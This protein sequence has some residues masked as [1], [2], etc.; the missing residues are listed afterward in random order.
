MSTFT[1]KLFYCYFILKIRVALSM[2]YVRLIILLICCATFSCTYAQQRLDYFFKQ[3]NQTD[4]LLHNEVRSITQDKKGYIWIAS[5]NGLQR[6]DGASFVNYPQMQSNPA[7]G[8]YADKVNNVLW[9]TDNANIE[10]MDL[11]KNVFQLYSK[12]TLLNNPLFTFDTYLDKNN[13]KWLLGDNAVY[14]YNSVTNKNELFQL[15][16]IP[17]NSH[18]ASFIVTDS[19]EMYS[20]V[21]TGST[22]F[23]FDK[24]NKRVYADSF[25]IA[26]IPLV[27]LSL[28]KQKSVLRY[29]MLDSK[30]NIWITTWG[31]V[32]IKINDETKKINTYSLSAIK[33]IQEGKKVSAAGLLINCMMEDN[34]HTIW[35]GTENAGLLKYNNEKDNFAYCIAQEKNSKGLQYTYKI[36]NLFQDKEQNIW[37]ATD[38]GISIFNPY[39]QYF[40]FIRHQED[41]PLSIS[42]SEIT[43]VLQTHNEDIYIGT[44]GNGISIYDKAFHFKKNIIFKGA[45][46][47]NFVWSFVQFNDDILWIGCQRGYLLQY[48][49]YTEKVQAMLPPEMEGSTIRCME[50]DNNGNI[51]FG[52]QNGKIV[53]WDN[54]QKKFFPCMSD[55][56]EDAKTSSFVHNIFIDKAQHC[57]VATNAGFKEFDVENRIFTNTW[58][59]NKNNTNSIST[60]ICKGI[61]ELNDS[62]L[63][64][65]TTYGGLN[66]FNK[67][68]KTFSHASTVDGLP[69]NS[70]YALKKDDSG[71]VWFTTDYGLY[72]FKSTDKKIIPYK[73]ENGQMNAAFE[74]KKFYPLKD[75]QWLSFTTSEAIAFFPYRTDNTTN[76]TQKIEITAFKVFDK[77]L[78]IDSI[79]FEKTPVQLSYKD[80]FFTISFAS[81]NFANLQQ[82]NYYYRLTGVDKDWVNAGNRRFANY[83]DVQP[84]EYLFEVKAD[85]INNTNEITSFKITI[86]PPFWKTWWFISLSALCILLLGFLF[87]K[88]REKSFKTIAAE[89]LKVQ[90]LN[91]EQ[92]KNKL[93]LE[94]IINYFSTSLIDK[95]TVDDV[96][97]DVAK[98]LIGKLGF[99]DC[100]MYL[101]NDDKTKMIQK[102]S[103][104]SKDSLEEINKQYFDVLPGQGLVGFVT[105]N[106]ESVVVA[107]TSK[108]SRYRQDEMARLSEITVPIIYN[109]E[110]LG[111]IDS[112]HPEKNFYTQQHLQ[113]LTTIA[114]LVGDKI[115]SIEAEQSLQRS[116]FE[117]YSINEQLSK[118]KLE[119]LRSQMNPHFIF[120]SLNAI[121]NLIQTNQKEKATTYLARFAK[122]IRNVLDS[123]KNDVVA[124][125]KDYETLELYLQMEQ[126]RCSDKFIYELKAEDELLYG[127]YKVLPLIV[128]PFVENAIH[129]GLLNKQIGDKKLI[130]SA[131]VENDYI[132][133]TITDNGVGR[134]KAQ[135][136]KE[137]NKPER[138]SYGI[139]I[140]KERIQLYNQNGETDNVII[141]DMFENNEPSGTKV[142]IRIKIF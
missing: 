86:K 115:K 28:K 18:Q 70:I 2:H 29:V 50:K 120:N 17:T 25:N 95:K 88:G 138:Q 96:L 81:L 83:T 14:K 40:S 134:K 60:K 137:I 92:Y 21:C 133:Y 6:Y 20:V 93:E 42:K 69:S 119:A 9:I 94:Q 53:K 10:K 52:L 110:L 68:T 30:K 47:N 89:K 114:T 13:E 118:A 8:M 108:D 105:Q 98:N 127:D 3:I 41:N 109:N 54:K 122:L 33:S 101:W 57:W 45:Y 66:F 102:A 56:P 82:T 117:M 76:T 48:N 78:F 44:W 74:S 113:L 72:K 73:I 79:L 80:N 136:L 16:I 36:F 112:E 121:D 22:L 63:L 99:V 23:L 24:K 131:I 5:N 43:S 130:V 58:L 67:K 65:G 7:V 125:Q 4:G 123:S 124:F 97:W 87:V 106:K 107:D 11:N 135:Q 71:F 12:E 111:I 32:L 46:E 104:G 91:A 116:Q 38:R 142:E 49:I 27:Q 34:N 90:Q 59:P 62:I 129:H 15:N 140:T 75:G 84:G 37:I 64:V 139:D 141:T 55:I 19:I 35:I 85:D 51:L 100:M 1:S 128:Q 103:V 126:F 132:T 61:E 77:F 31:D 39:E 26:N